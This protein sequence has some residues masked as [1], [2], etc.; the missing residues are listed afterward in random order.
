MDDLNKA[1]GLWVYCDS[2][3]ALEAITNG[4]YR[5]TQEIC[6]LLETIGQMGRTCT[7]QWMPACIGIDGYEARDL[8]DTTTCLVTMDDA[9]AIEH[10]RFKEIS[11]DLFKEIIVELD[12]LFCILSKFIFKL[13]S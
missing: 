9:N 6:R 2:K 13:L 8:N 10:Y 5:L 7:M 4:H 1:N 12:F 11:R 3:A